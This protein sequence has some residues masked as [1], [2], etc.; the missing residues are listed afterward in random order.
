MLTLAALR[1]LY[2]EDAH[3]SPEA[4]KVLGFSDNRQDAALQVGHFNDF[5]AGP[6]AAGGIALRSAGA[7]PGGN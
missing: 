7:V 6:P 4:K 3:L 5:P 1:Y 2:E